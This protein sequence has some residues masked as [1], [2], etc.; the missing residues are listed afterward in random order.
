MIE[1]DITNFD[2]NKTRKKF[3]DNARSAKRAAR[4]D[5]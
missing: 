3:G 2:K 1:I 4:G 5:P